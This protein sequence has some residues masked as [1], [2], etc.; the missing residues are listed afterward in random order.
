[1]SAPP[2]G[3]S[4]PI[5]SRDDLVLALEK[6]CKPA[7]QW[8]IGT[9]HEKFLYDLRD[10]SAAPFARDDA[11]AVGGAGDIQTLFSA[12]VSEFGWTPLYEGENVIALTRE[13]ANITLEPGGQ[14]ELSGAVFSD[15][16]QTRAETLKH[17]GEIGTLCQ[18]LGL[19][20]LGLGYQ[21][22]LTRDQVP[23]MPKARYRIMGAY[24]Q[25]KGQLGLD[26]MKSTATVQVN[27]DFSSEADMVRKLR[28][29]LALQPVATAMFANSPFSGGK[30]NGYRS[31]RSAIWQDTDPDRTGGMDFAFEDG[32][33]F[34]RYV[35]Y[36]LDVP[37][38]FVHRDGVY[39]DASGL[40]FRDFMARKLPLRPGEMPL[41][42][43]WDDH[44]TTL[45]PEVRLKRFM[46]MRGADG[47]PWGRL[48]A[49]PAL[50]AGLCYDSDALEAAWALCRDFTREERNA[51]RAEAPI[52]GL[53]TPF[54]D[55]TLGDI[56]R[57]VVAI[58]IEGLRRRGRLDARDRDETIYLE[59]LAEIAETGV[60]PAEHLL[61]LYH[62]RWNQSVDPVFTEFAY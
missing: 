1:M 40:S 39:L 6:G 55:G 35:D 34:E 51:L 5:Q 61:A 50:W 11:A 36:A 18:R 19:G 37:M 62:G 41:K 52:H 38:Y 49:L 28:I 54:R 2:T 30:L 17:V 48:C 45:F 32:M 56:A 23:W 25:K 8:R 7:S 29:S 27:L 42:S 59:G 9:E 46:E 15:L 47:G 60:T 24:M 12:L 21:P 31:F 53:K 33:G 4:Q 22:E 43:D 13:G 44:L 58:A 3:I 26:M 20:A 10:F 57:E 16:H 14:F